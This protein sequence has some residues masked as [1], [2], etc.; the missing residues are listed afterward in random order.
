V[1]LVTINLRTPLLYSCLLFLARTPQCYSQQ[2]Q[3]PVQ[4]GPPQPGSQQQQT[5]APKPVAKAPAAPADDSENTGDGALSIEPW[6]W[7]STSKPL[8]RGGFLD[9]NTYPSTIQ[10]PDRRPISPGILLNIPAGRFNTLRISY[11][12]TQRSANTIANQNLTVYSVNYAPGDLLATGYK[13]RNVKAV[14]DYLSFP[15]P[16]AGH[17]FRL[18]T[19]WGVQYTT[20]HTTIDAPLKTLVNDS[21]GNP[22]P[23]SGAATRSIIFPS[24]GLGF[25][26][27]VS[28]F[29]RLEGEA[30]GFAIPY[31]AVI[32][33]A[34]GSAAIRAHHLEFLLGYKT[35]H[36]KTSPKQEDYVS[37]NMYGPYVGIRWYWK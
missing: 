20:I 32:W 7:L 22:I 27:S 34:E 21:S 35:F 28:R 10:F 11:F 37:S 18:K 5:S 23:N 33:D 16:P 1:Q 14:W 29:F 6:G 3:A 24:L 13:L 8:L 4:P 15:F 26:H 36:F 17:K 2:P 30:S 9:T 25:E 12:Q 31:H 19:L